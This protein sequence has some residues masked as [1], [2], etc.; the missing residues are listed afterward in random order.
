MEANGD[1]TE[2]PADLTDKLSTLLVSEEGNSRFLGKSFLAKSHYSPSNSLTG[3]SS[4]FSLFSPQGLQW[5]S[6]KTG[7]NDLSESISRIASTKTPWPIGQTEIWYPMSP[8]DRE[9]LP[10]KQLADLYVSRG[11]PCSISGNITK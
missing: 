5:I 1:K 8:L 11:S 4:G 2:S 9:P 10:P 6:E 7:S 3:A